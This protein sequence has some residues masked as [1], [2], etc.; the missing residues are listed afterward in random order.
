[1]A[2]EIG[3]PDIGAGVILFAAPQYLAL[4]WISKRLEA[5]PKRAF[6]IFGKIKVGTQGM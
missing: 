6:P 3:L 2:I 1:M 4:L 5:P